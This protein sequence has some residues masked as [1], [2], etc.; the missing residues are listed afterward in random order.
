MFSVKHTVAFLISALLA[1]SLAGCQTLP[2]STNNEGGSASESG[3]SA[4]EPENPWANE[5]FAYFGRLDNPLPSYANADADV[6]FADLKD[7]DIVSVEALCPLVASG[8]LTAEE[9]QTFTD[10]LRAMTVDV[11]EKTES[12]LINDAGYPTYGGSLHGGALWFDVG[13]ADGSTWLMHLKLSSSTLT[14]YDPGAA[15]LYA[16]GREYWVHGGTYDALDELFSACG[17]RV[18]ET[19]PS[20]AMPFADLTREDVV[21]ADYYYS[22]CFTPIAD[23]KIDELVQILRGI[24]VDPTTANNWL[25]SDLYGGSPEKFRIVC[26]DGSSHIVGTWAGVYIDGFVYQGT[27]EGLDGFFTRVWS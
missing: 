19:L 14:Y 26:S 13:F 22:G 25:R 3:S 20:E 21:S 9:R 23:E 7:S 18:M 5:I 6:P 10:V 2:P 11:E 17:E 15:V 27:V 4:S 24:T 8:E 1:F 16:G 12:S